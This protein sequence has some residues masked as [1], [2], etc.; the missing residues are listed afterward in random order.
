MKNFSDFGIRIP[1]IL[2]PKNLNLETW[3]VIAC[4][5]YTQDKAYWESVEKI[6]GNDR[7]TLNLI[8]PEQK[9]SEETK[10]EQLKKIEQTMNEYCTDN[11]FASPKNAF[12][13]VERTSAFGRK[14]CGLIACLDLEQYEWKSGKTSLVRATEKTIYERALA[15]KAIRE[16]ASLDLSHIMLLVNDPE[17]LLIEKIGKLIEKSIDEKKE[18]IEK[19]YS[20]SLMKNGGNIL[21]YFVPSSMHSMMINAL[22]K[23]SRQNKQ[24]DGSVFLFAAGDG[25]HSLAAAKAVWDEAKNTLSESEKL[26]S[27]L[28]YALVEIVNL[29][30]TGLKVYPIHRA[31]F[32]IDANAFVAAF[33]TKFAVSEK[34]FLTF[35]ELKDCTRTSSCFGFI[36]QNPKE[37]GNFCYKCVFIK[38]SNLEIVLFQDFADNYISEH[39]NISLDFIHGKEEVHRLCKEKNALGII[40]PNVDMSRFFKTISTCGSLPR[41][42][43]SLGKADE[44]RF[45][46]ETRKLRKH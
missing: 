13:Y 20:G 46:L 21:A 39:K 11:F 38:N 23:I 22:E 16:S 34:N 7:S 25:N 40:M 4:D 2:L 33:A 37:H 10:D 9:L 8:L 3:A 41:K 27:P 31:F 15:R 29:Y 1:D 24:E 18:K 45:Y 12:V 30:S 6:V 17:F 43:F 35:E 14:R 42:S 36:Y 28:R 5:Q 26:N 19:A 32:N 44:K